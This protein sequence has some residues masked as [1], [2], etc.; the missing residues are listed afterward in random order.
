MVHLLSSRAAIDTHHQRVLSETEVG[1]H[2]NEI[3]TSEAIRDIKAWY[4]AAIR[5][6]EA[7]YGT[8]LRKAE[9]V[10]LASTSKAAVIQA[11]GIRKAEAANAA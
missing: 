8:T 1:H 3:N 10:H 7:S 6:A 11:T 5:D 9:A 4:A 2:Q